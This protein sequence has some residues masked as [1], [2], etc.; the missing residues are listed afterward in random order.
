MKKVYVGIV[1]VMVLFAI[2]SCAST[3]APVKEA[4]ETIV[5]Q[6][7]KV[8]GKN[9][10]PQP[11][12]VTTEVKTDDKYY[13]SASAK[14]ANQ[15]N[16][17]KAARTQAKAYLAEYVSSLISE[18]T[19]Y[20]ANEAGVN[21]NTEAMVGFENAIKD[22]AEAMLTGVMQEDMWEAEDGTI[23]VLMSMPL[24]NVEQNLQKALDE[25]AKASNT[26]VENENAT[27]AREYMTTAMAE[28][29]SN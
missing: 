15:S 24:E 17:I 23:W 4:N 26:Y 3:K 20:Y 2:V 28:L 21:G 13:A 12:W 9:G 8:L 16:A 22:K 29:A 19:K 5:A 1:C 10:V 18:F 27:R 25:A 7:T 14:F 6:N 11:D